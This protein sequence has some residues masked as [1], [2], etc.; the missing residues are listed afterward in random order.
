MLY[1]TELQAHQVL[2]SKTQPHFTSCAR[3]VPEGRLFPHVCP[4][5]VE[6]LT[7]A[8]SGAA[9]LPRPLQGAVRPAPSLRTLQQRT[10]IGFNS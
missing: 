7:L 8:F 4:Q 1:P 5:F 9:L 6:N 3:L 10:Y 2:T